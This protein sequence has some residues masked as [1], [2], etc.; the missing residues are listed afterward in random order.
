MSLK[1]MLTQVP[2]HAGV[3]FYKEVLHNRAISIVQA[4][5]ALD[6]GRENLCLFCQGKVSLNEK[7]AQDLSEFSGTGKEVWMN[8]QKNF[9]TWQ[10]NQ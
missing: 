4:A 3:F 8:L 10:T 9:D 2:T 1:P 6:W 5:D 7:M